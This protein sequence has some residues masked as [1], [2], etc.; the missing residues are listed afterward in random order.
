M[1]KTNVKIVVC[2]NLTVAIKNLLYLKCQKCF[3]TLSGWAYELW[4]LV[5][6]KR[7]MKK[8]NRINNKNK[9]KNKIPNYNI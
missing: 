5:V 1:S 4:L 9:F 7:V 8:K 6:G 3:A 2:N